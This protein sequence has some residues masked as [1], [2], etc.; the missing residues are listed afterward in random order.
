MTVSSVASLWPAPTM[1]VYGLAAVFL[2][3]LPA[4]VFLIP[5]ALV[6][7][8]LARL[9]RLPLGDRGISPRWGFTPPGTSTR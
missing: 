3:V 5:T 7:A 1:A 9:E 8:E 4:I 6:S 2:Y